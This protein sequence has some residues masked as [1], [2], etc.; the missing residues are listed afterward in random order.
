MDAPGSQ[1]IYI[2]DWTCAEVYLNIAYTY[3]MLLN[4]GASSDFQQTWERD[5]T[6]PPCCSLVQN[7]PFPLTWDI[8]G[9]VTLDAGFSQESYPFT[10][11]S[12]AR[13]DMPKL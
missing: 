6:A 3:K 8:H 12:R 11:L 13:A 1:I 4:D 5:S 10:R 2:I 9:L 7:A